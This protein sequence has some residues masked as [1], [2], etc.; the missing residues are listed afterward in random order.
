MND[1][2]SMDNKGHL[3]NALNT[4]NQELYTT[5]YLARIV[6]LNKQIAGFR[7]AVEDCERKNG[8]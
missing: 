1:P 8:N 6:R 3:A 7:K 5:I 2:L 4:N